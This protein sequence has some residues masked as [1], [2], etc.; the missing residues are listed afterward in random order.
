MVESHI[1][2]VLKLED[3]K[4]TKLLKRYREVRQD[5]RDRLEAARGDS[6]TAQRLRGVLTQ[7]EAAI[8]AMNISLLTGMKEVAYDSAIMGV[9]HQLVEIKKFDK[10]FRGAVTPI[11]LDVLTVAEDTN[12][13]LLNRYESS[14]DA[15]GQDLI[16]QLTTALTTEALAE[17]SLSS[18]IGRL[19]QFFLGEEWKIQRIARTELHNVYNIAKMNGMSEVNEKY[20]PDLM[21]TLVHP[22]DKRTGDDSKALARRNLIVPVS[23]PFVYTWKGKKRIFMAPPDRPNDRAILVPYRQ[24][25]D[26]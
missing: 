10:H 18:V 15:Y 26:N 14:L 5:L 22:M 4:A 6:F 24:A 11:N 25:W 7:V 16:N 8:E 23:E 20:L 19:G 21:K 2:E 9:E 12:N 17:S 1:Q 13:F 3:Q